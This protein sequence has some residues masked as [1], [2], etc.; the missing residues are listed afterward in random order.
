MTP[1]IASRS[2][3]VRPTEAAR[4]ETPSAAF[5]VGAFGVAVF[6]DDA[7][8]VVPFVAARD[9]AAGAFE[10]FGLVAAIRS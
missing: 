5:G 8:P 10:R 7:F 4:A 1:Y 3:S 9:F 6:A 2:A